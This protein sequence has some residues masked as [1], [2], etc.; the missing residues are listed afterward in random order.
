MRQEKKVSSYV[1]RLMDKRNMVLMKLQ[2]VFLDVMEHA[3]T[4]TVMGMQNVQNVTDGT[5]SSIQTLNAKVKAWMT[6]S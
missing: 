6:L 3:Q 2:C 5:A 1:Y 4:A